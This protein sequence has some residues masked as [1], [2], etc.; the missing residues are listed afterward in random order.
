MPYISQIKARANNTTKPSMK[1][2]R[3][4]VK[5]VSKTGSKPV[6]QP[7]DPGSRKRRLQVISDGDSSDAESQDGPQRSHTSKW[8]SEK[9]QQQGKKK[10]MRT[11]TPPPP[12]PPI[13]SDSDEVE[14]DNTEEDM[15]MDMGS[16]DEV[17]SMAGGR[18]RKTRHGEEAQITSDNGEAPAKCKEN[19]EE[20]IKILTDAHK[21]GKLMLHAINLWVEPENVLLEG[22]EGLVDPESISQNDLNLNTY[23]TLTAMWSIDLSNDLEYFVDANDSV[24]KISIALHKGFKLARQEDTHKIRDSILKI[25]VKDPRKESLPLPI[26]MI[27]SA[28]GFN[29][30][31]TACLLCPQVYLETFNT[32]GEWCQQLCEGKVKISHWELPSFLFDQLKASPEEDLAGS[33]WGYVLVRMVKHLLTS[34][35]IP[36]KSKGP[37]HPSIVKIYK[38]N[39]ITGHIIVYGACQARYTLSSVDGWTCC[40]GKFDLQKFYEVI[41]DMYEDFPEDPWAVESLA[42]WNKEIFGNSV[43]SLDF[44]GNG[45]TN[46]G[47][48]LGN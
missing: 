35:G 2:T 43:M 5:P 32:D 26:P 38:I 27:K 7:E 25:I 16:G 29:Y 4:A 46:S 11:Q 34:D 48:R 21:W 12:P 36:G 15:D 3:P 22:I 10:K 41:V 31:E 19:L 18:G 24:S 14:E 20:C 37:T 47:M 40:D 9:L 23:D 33:M 30:S 17:G 44:H 28:Q 1:S 8:S 42:W 39:K 6:T 45:N 13:V